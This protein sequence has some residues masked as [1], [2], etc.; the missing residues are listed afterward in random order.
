[1]AFSQGPTPDPGF[2]LR[3]TRGTPEQTLYRGPDRRLADA[4]VDQWNRDLRRYA[5]G[6]PGDDGGDPGLGRGA[7]RHPGDRPGGH[8]PAHA[9][10]RMAG[11]GDVPGR[12]PEL[13][14][15]DAGR[16]PGTRLGRRHAAGAGVLG[17][18]PNSTRS[19]ALP[20]HARA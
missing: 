19:P 2:A 8:A 3:R 13:H 6:V 14:L 16:R 1:A 11:P 5:G 15:D 20:T 4:V 7:G 10:A 17:E 9:P 18:P 12:G